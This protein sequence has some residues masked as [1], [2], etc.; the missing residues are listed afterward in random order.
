[1]S[2]HESLLTVT[3]LTVDFRGVRGLA[4][5]ISG[6][7]FEVDRGQTVAFLG[8]SGSGKTVSVLS[9]LRLLPPTAKII[10]GKAIFDGVDLLREPE[11]KMRCIRGKRIGMVFQE[12]TLCFNPVLSVGGHFVETLTMSGLSRGQ[13]RR[14]AVELLEMVKIPEAGLRVRRYPHEFSG[15]M[16]QRIMIALALCR[17]PEI[18]IGDEPTTSVDATTQLEI[19]ELLSSLVKAHGVALILI[20]HNIAL[21]ARYSDYIYVFHWGKIVEAGEARELLNIPLH[22]VTIDLSKDW[23]WLGERGSKAEEVGEGHRVGVGTS[24]AIDGGCVYQRLCKLRGEEC[25]GEE[26]A[27][28]PVSKGHLVACHRIGR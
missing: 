4:R 7:S 2:A 15:G 16:L 11:E 3:G 25:Y 13:A 27:L 1:M 9:L 19:L 23:L 28:R 21:A 6:L 14:R 17:D 5:A 12:P 18:V 22:P 8:P 26:P 24:T 20:T 10:S